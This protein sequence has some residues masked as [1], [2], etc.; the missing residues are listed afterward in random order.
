M[1]GFGTVKTLNEQPTD[2]DAPKN[3]CVIADCGELPQGAPLAVHDPDQVGLSAN[4][5]CTAVV[6]LCSA[7]APGST[8]ALQ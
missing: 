8:T 2:G 1:Q 5:P 3:K 4:A 7:V 6:G